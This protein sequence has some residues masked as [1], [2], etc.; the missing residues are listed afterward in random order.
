MLLDQIH[1]QAI[2]LTEH[3]Q[4]S[5]EKPHIEAHGIQKTKRDTSSSH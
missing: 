2:K 4:I 3:K 1:N 5:I